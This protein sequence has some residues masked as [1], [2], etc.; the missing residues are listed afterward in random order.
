MSNAN[1]Y[2]LI[3]KDNGNYAI[4]CLICNLTSHNP[5]DVKYLF[6]GYCNLFHD[7]DQSVKDFI[8]TQNKEKLWTCKSTFKMLLKHQEPIQWQIQIN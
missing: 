8:T 6:C 5:N 1:S 2:Q 3:K 4:K 7:S